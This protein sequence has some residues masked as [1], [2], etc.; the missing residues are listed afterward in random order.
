[1]ASVHGQLRA[2]VWSILLD[3]VGATGHTIAVGRFRRLPDD[4]DLTG[5]ERG[6]E[7]EIRQREPVAGYNSPLCG[8]GL[9]LSTL[10]VRVRYIV[11]RGETGY[12]GAGD[13]SG[14][15]DVEQVEDRAHDDAAVILDALGQQTAWASVTDVDVIDPCAVVPSAPPPP[16]VEVGPER[17]TL[18]VTAYILTRAVHSTAYGPTV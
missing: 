14:G 3:G 2:R 13:Q 11:A 4:A 12:D 17:A 16:V 9:Y 15:G 10:V 6:V 1:M 8:R 7:V 18:T 5:S